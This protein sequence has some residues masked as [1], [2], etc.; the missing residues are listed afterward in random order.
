MRSRLPLIAAITFVLGLELSTG[1]LEY[2]VSQY[3]DGIE[4]FLN[5]NIQPDY[6]GMI[7]GTLL[8][9]SGAAGMGLWLWTMVMLQDVTNSDLCPECGSETR[10]VRR[11]PSQRLLSMIARIRVSRRSCSRCSWNGLTTKA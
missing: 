3:R 7:A 5:P 11:T 1:F 4:T 2:I 8:I 10:R 9:L 6:L